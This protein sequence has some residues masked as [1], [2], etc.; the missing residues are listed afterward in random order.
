[1]ANRIRRLREARWLTQAE[2]AKRA[3]L[4]PVSLARI[5]TGA[6]V[7]RVTTLRRLAK[8]LGVGVGKLI[9]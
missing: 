6:A 5:E 7:P 4:H 2:L 1:M 3:R 9:G 8:A